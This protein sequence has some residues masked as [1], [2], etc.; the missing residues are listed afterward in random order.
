MNGPLPFA[1]VVSVASSPGKVSLGLSRRHRLSG[2]ILEAMGEPLFAVQWNDRSDPA[3]RPFAMAVL[4]LH[5]TRSLSESS[6]RGLYQDLC[7]RKRVAVLAEAVGQPIPQRVLKLLSRTTWQTFSCRDWP[8]FFSIA[9]GQ[10]HS[11][12]NHGVQITP[13]LVRQFALIPDELRTPRVMSVVSTLP[14]PAERWRKWQ[15]FLDQADADQRQEFRRAAGAINTR[16]DFWDLYF[17]CEGKYIQPFS[18]PES[19][20]ESPL[21]EPIA[22][23][24]DMVLEGFRMGNCLANRISRVQSGNRIFFKLR[25]G[26]PI[27]AE[28]IR[29]GQAWVP[30]DILGWQNTSVPPETAEA[31]GTEMHRL[32][33]SASLTASTFASGSEDAYVAELRQAARDACSAEDI[34]MLAAPLH[35]IQAK[36]ISW[37]NGAYAIFELEGS[38]YLQFM[39]SPDGKEYLLEINSHKYGS[40]IHALLSEDTV[41]LIESAGFVWPT[42]TANFLRWF[43]VSSPDDID[44]MAELGLAILTRM[45]G[46]RKSRTVIV[47]THIPA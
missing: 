26:A 23:P 31:I 18:I 7:L 33:A 43:N 28:L 17:R 5:N 15:G 34:A 12:L 14:L 16:G 20:F 37:R 42:G 11:A 38:G 36:S 25:G 24:Q 30:G 45:F 41:N 22:S 13:T 47:Q 3:F 9:T 40:T 1:P 27:N 29:Q 21:V 4:D 6:R 8:A 46:Y 35:S 19:F 44:A 39:S 10:G 2:I 32:A